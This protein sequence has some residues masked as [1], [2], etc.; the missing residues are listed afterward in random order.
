MITE[1]V[2]VR[3]TVCLMA[4]TFGSSAACS[5]ISITGLKDWNGWCSRMSPLRIGAE[6]VAMLAAAS[7]ACPGRNGVNFS[8]G[9][10]TM[11]GTSHQP[12]QVDRAVDAVQVLLGELELLQQELGHFR[13]A[14]FGHLQAHRIAEVALRQ[15]AGECGAQVLDFLLVH[16]Q[17][18][19]ARHA[20]RIRAI[21]DHA[22]EQRADE[23]LQ[24]RAELHELMSPFRP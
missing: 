19:V 10:S 24:D 4:T 2:P 15:L 22:L 21:D 14:G 12:H 13:R 9:R 8:A 16:E 3:Y 7:W 1:S 5:S 11:S 18:A 23:R 20:E 6:D 17:V